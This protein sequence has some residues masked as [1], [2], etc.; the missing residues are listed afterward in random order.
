MTKF[1][2]FTKFLPFYQIFAIFSPENVLETTASNLLDVPGLFVVLDGLVPL[3]AL[4][5]VV[6]DLVPRLLHLGIVAAGPQKLQNLNKQGDAKV[7]RVN[8]IL[9]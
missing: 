2:H 9:V 4:G 6:A 1:G 8:V 7:V 5:E 3:V